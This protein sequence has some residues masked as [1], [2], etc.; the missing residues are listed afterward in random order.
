LFVLAQSFKV[1]FDVTQTPSYYT[2]LND[3]L[4]VAGTF[5]N[6]KPKDPNFKLNRLTYNKFYLMIDLMAG[7]HQYKFTRG[8][9]DTVETNLDGTSALNRNIE[10]NSDTK[11]TVTISN[12]ED[13]KGTHTAIG[14]THLLDTNFDYPQF[15]RTKRIWIYL[16]TDYYYAN[17]TKRYPVIY[18]H[19]GQ[20][21]FD[22]LYSFAGEWNVDESME[23]F[24]QQNK[25]TA[26][27]VAIE[28]KGVGANGER[29]D[30]LTPFPNNT[31]GG[32]KG[33]LY[34]NFLVNN[35]KPYVDAHFR[36]KPQREFTSVF[37][38][39]LGG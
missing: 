32:G 33:D 38:S 31:L 3:D 8:S 16:P 9:W 21:V 19:D 22:K 23:A 28:T 34:L 30:E 14:N 6:W 1:E 20:N 27:V 11:Q 10:I 37:G 2:P 25:E 29:L 35:V 7:I 36:T 18:M 13:M 24:Y 15:N 17:N 39:S 26:I 12:W 4:Y 5:N